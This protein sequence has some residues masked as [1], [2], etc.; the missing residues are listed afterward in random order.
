FR[1]LIVFYTI[2]YFLAFLSFIFFSEE[3]IS[4]Q[5]YSAF[6]RNIPP[7][8]FVF[9]FSIFALKQHK[10]PEIQINNNK[11]SENKYSKSG[12]NK[13]ECD[14]LYLKIRKHIE[15]SKLYLDPELTL[16]ELA[17]HMGETR[18][19]VSE[20]INR[21]TSTKFYSFINAFRL[22]EF[23]EAVKSNR[24][25]DYTIISIAFECGFGS[26][27]TFYKLFKKEYN[28]TPKQFLEDQ[29]LVKKGDAG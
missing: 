23:I 19:R 3:N 16:N 6:A 17:E 1:N 5:S 8:L 10:L 15:C 12:I 13:K 9:F 29:T 26:S 22:E 25:P 18:H 21:G 11:E 7:I 28:I 14:K 20:A 27:S 24:F 4:Y 2:I